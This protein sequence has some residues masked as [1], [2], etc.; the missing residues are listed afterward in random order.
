MLFEVM[1]D[2]VN[3]MSFFG[4]DLVFIFNIMCIEKVFEMDKVKDDY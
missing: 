2:E 1:L 4:S 3:E